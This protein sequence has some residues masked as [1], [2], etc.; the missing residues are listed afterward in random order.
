MQTMMSRV[1]LL[2]SLFTTLASA[3]TYDKYAGMENYTSPSGG[4][5]FFRVEKA[6]N[7]GG[8]QHWLLVDPLGNYVVLQGMA[9]FNPTDGG[10]HVGGADYVG[11]VTSK[12]GDAHTGFCNG[13][14]PRLIQFGWN[15]L[16]ED[17]LNYCL[18]YLPKGHSQLPAVQVPVKLQ[19]SG[20]ADA[21]RG[22]NTKSPVDDIVS[23]LDAGVGSNYTYHGYAGDP[24]PDF[25]NPNFATEYNASTAN[26]ESN[27]NGANSQPWIAGISVG[28]GDWFFCMRH[29]T[30]ANCGWLIMAASPIVT[31]GNYYNVVFQDTALYAKNNAISFLEKKYGAGSEGLAALNAAWGSNYQ[32]WTTNA[33]SYSGEIV[34][35][36]DGSRT[37]YTGNTSQAPDLLSLSISLGNPTC[38]TTLIAGTDV[39]NRLNGPALD[40][41]GINKV[42]GTSVTITFTTAPASGT[43]ICASYRSGGWPAHITGS[44]AVADEDGG[45]SWMGDHL[46][47]GTNGNVANDL[48]AVMSAFATQGFSTMNK[49]LR[50]YEPNHLIWSADPMDGGTWSQV[51]QAICPYVDVV[52]LGLSP[53][54]S[55][56]ENS[57]TNALSSWAQNCNKPIDVRPILDAQADSPG[58]KVWSNCNPQ[59]KNSYSTQ[60]QRGRAE[61]QILET[62]ASFTNNSLQPLVGTSLFGWQDK[63][64]GGTVVNQTGVVDSLDNAYGWQN[65]ATGNGGCG[66]TTAG[67]NQD[68]VASSMDS[69]GYAR[70]GEAYCYGDYLDNSLAGRIA[71][72]NAMCQF[73]KG[74][75]CPTQKGPDFELAV[76]PASSSIQ[77]GSAAKFTITATG[78]NGFSSP[79]TLNCGAGLPPSTTCAFAASAITP[80]TAPAASTLTISTTASSASSNL[81][82]GGDGKA[83]YAIWVLSPVMLVSSMTLTAFRLRSTCRYWLIA[84]VIVGV[85][86]MLS[87]VGASQSAAPA[88]ATPAGT[89]TITISASAGTI[90]HTMSLTLLVQ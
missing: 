41:K 14:L 2:L 85:M 83:L 88:S 34:A 89:Y 61:A 29:N 54:E 1:V 46:L 73:L 69:Y 22:T 70:G 77:Q 90:K 25:Y 17:S 64:T 19:D 86:P 74:T 76:S 28:D 39:H 50:T 62:A 5:G 12:Y 87:C 32:S 81:V 16:A 59:T 31:W 52:V 66:G 6:S 33:A 3:Q 8:Q 71:V 10:N 9:D 30:S 48:N 57:V 45:G 75:N 79:I 43:R 18:P 15:S 80:G 55:N 82:S 37:S 67:I 42:S 35:T 36:S 78:Q 13:S 51:K 38:S 65:S 11:V 44:T 27:Q 58:C 24:L 4:S 63:V 84:L 26:L 60:T 56:T 40:A 47:N 49:A 21:G 20:G 23:A 68:N 72:E 53:D 7:A